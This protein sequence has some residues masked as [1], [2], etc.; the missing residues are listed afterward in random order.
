M[1]PE[2]RAGPSMASVTE[3][4]IGA[5]TSGQRTRA[6]D[7]ALLTSDPGWDASKIPEL[8]RASIIELKQVGGVEIELLTESDDDGWTVPVSILS[9]Q[10]GEINDRLFV[11][12]HQATRLRRAC[13]IAIKRDAEH[14]CVVLIEDEPI[15][16]RL[17]PTTGQDPSEVWA[18]LR[19]AASDFLARPKTLGENVNLIDEV[20]WIFD[21][22]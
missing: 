7:I 9:D 10:D 14:I 15:Q 5:P 4:A 12:D 1:E 11:E 2:I 16:F 22:V 20:R 13:V 19:C 18:T 21:G 6:V 8:L 3:V 17:Y